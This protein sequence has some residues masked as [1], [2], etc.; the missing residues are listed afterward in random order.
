MQNGFALDLNLCTGCQA[1]VVACAIE[2]EL[3]WG[4]SWRWV[5]TFNPQHVPELPLYHLSLACNHCADA[6]CMHH[7]PALA[8]SKDD[9]TGAVLLDPDACIG[10]KYCTWACPYDAPRYDAAAG[11]VSKCTFC[12]HRQEEGLAP[13]CVTQCPTSALHFG[14]V[15][16]L[17]GQTAVGGFPRT[18]ADPSIRF[19]DLRGDAPYPQQAPSGANAV[20]AAA[21]IASTTAGSD[22]VELAAALPARQPNQ[23]ELKN[24][25]P[26]L[27]FS[28][29][30]AFLV[31]CM[32]TGAGRQALGLPLFVLLAAMAAGSSTL[33]LGR[34]SRAWRAV[35]NWRR[36]WLSREILGFGSFASL[37]ALL[38]S[39]LLSNEWLG[40]LVA[41]LGFAT[42]FA[43]D[44]V[45][46]V[47]RTPDL[48]EHSAQTLLT[49]LLVAGVVG[50]HP[51]LWL[52]VVG[53]KLL[54]YLRRGWKRRRLA[55]QRGPT[56][57]THDR[58]LLWGALR[59]IMGLVLPTLL[60]LSNSTTPVWLLGL[61]V[62]CGEM[63]DR[64]EFYLE[65]RIPSPSRQMVKDLQGALKQQTAA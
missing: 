12:H 31:G 18:E 52:S 6:P 7:C 14:V 51:A 50:G 8:Y 46:Q 47:T 27:V 23:T 33:H 34:T 10:C 63:I 11:V 42:L 38:L 15:D 41:A 16:Q 4:S 44:R 26:L 53:L 59:V 58:Q 25:W 20:S 21:G 65:L 40:P 28:L 49:G 48:N 45:Y 1:C 57:I 29:L 32:A 2:N 35:L 56:K 17:D 3:P 64:A 30:C 55:A 36:S 60:Y 43:I 5:E 22:L 39:G 37:S 24:E 19:V 61:L 54:L 62:A 9:A 13:A